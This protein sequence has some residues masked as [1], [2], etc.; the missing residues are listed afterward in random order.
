[1]YVWPEDA[2]NVLLANAFMSNRS[3]PG[4]NA[5]LIQS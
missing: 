2:T 3:K 5:F 1:M 4:K